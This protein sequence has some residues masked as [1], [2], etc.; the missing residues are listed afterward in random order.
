MNSRE[1]RERVLIALYRRAM[2][3][4]VQ[5]YY[6][7]KE[8]SEA[9]GLTWR[10]G[11]LRTVM[12]D[13]DQGG[14]V[15]LSQTMGG[16]ADGGMDFRMTQRGIEQAED[17]IE[18]NIE[19]EEDPDETYSVAGL[20]PASNRYVEISDNQREQIQSPLGELAEALRG[21]NEL[22]E[23][24]RQIILSEIAVFEATMAAP[25]VSTELVDRFVTGVLKGLILA[26]STG[27]VATL[28][29]R[30]IDTLALIF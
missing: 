14:L 10:P 23:E 21:S 29:E 15:R 16:G 4:G 13:L 25:R 20:V 22:D 17:L 5:G 27:L 11:Q 12:T 19:Y 3:D 8:T 26:V 9:V 6:D 18:Q 1:F 7:P 24:D 30:L 28:A 2:R